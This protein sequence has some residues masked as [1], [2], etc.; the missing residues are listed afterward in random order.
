[1]SGITVS[2]VKVRLNSYILLCEL[3]CEFVVPIAVLIVVPIAVL[4][5]VPIAVVPV[6]V[7][8]AG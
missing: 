7:L 4:I 3:M 6:V 8:I 2:I 1:M 5:V